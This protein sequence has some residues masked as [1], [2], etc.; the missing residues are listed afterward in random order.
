MQYLGI[1]WGTRRASWCALDRHGALREGVIPADQDGLGRLALTLDGEDVR[2]CIEMMSGAVWVGDRLATVGWEI[3]LADARKVKSIAPL[4]CK[5]DP[6]RE[7]PHA[8]LIGVHVREGNQS[9]ALREFERYRLRLGA[10]LGLEPTARLR[11]LL[12]R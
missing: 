8:A 7:S 5:T 1:D 10:A 3:R 12:P 6:L 11:A 4:A 2:G 9:E